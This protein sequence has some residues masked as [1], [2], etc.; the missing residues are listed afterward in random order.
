MRTVCMGLGMVLAIAAAASAKE[1]GRGDR[2]RIKDETIVRGTTTRPILAVQQ[3][4]LCVPGL[5]DEQLIKTFVRVSETGGT[6]LCF[7]LQGFN[8]DGTALDAKNV[9]TAMKLKDAA[10]FRW[11]PTVIHVL[12]SL[13]NADEA[14]RLNAIRTTAKTF[15]N[16][17]SVLYWIDGPKSGELAKEFRKLAPNVIVLAE[18]GGDVMLISDAKAA[19]KG[20]ASLLLGALPPTD[21]P[22]KHCILPDDQTSYDALEEYSRQPAELKPWTPSTFGLTE[23]EKKDGWISLFDGKTLD[24]WSIVGDNKK[25]FEA[26]DGM[27]SWV[28]AGGRKLQSRD[29]YDNF[30]LRAEWKIYAPKGNNGMYFRAPRANRES[31]MGFEFQ[32]FGDYGKKP[33]KNSTGSVYDVVPPKANAGKPEGEWNQIEVTLN[34]SLY[35]ATL[36]GVLIQDLDFDKNPELKYRLRNGFICISDHGN[37]ASFRNIRLKKL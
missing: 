5:S 14:M 16:V 33:D 27:I 9:Q 7:D 10:N 12:G 36:N 11:M 18:D 20:K 28:A 29:R 24:G 19:I 30:T 35:K 13:Q 1:D 8:A 17:W 31:K 22:V 23:E 4:N 32:M 26:K 3:T 2:L 34:G 15:A 6:A 37:K 21:A 25:G